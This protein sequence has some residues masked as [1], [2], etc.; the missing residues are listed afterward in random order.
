MKRVDLSKGDVFGKWVVCSFAGVRS[1]KKQYWTCVCECGKMKDL[2]KYELI[3]GKTTHCGCNRKKP[4]GYGIDLSGNRYGKL[5][6]VSFAYRKNRRPYW[7]CIC[8]CG[9][10]KILNGESIK[11][12]YTTSCGCVFKKVVKEVN[13]THGLS[14][15][16][17]YNVWSTMRARC[18]NPNNKSYERYGGRGIKVCK[19][20]GKFSNFYEDMGASYEAGLSIERLKVNKGYYK[21]NCIWS[22]TET[23]SMNK[24]NTLRVTI[25]GK[26]MTLK[27]WCKLSEISYKTAFRRLKIGWE[28]KDA[29]FVKLQRQRK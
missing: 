24:T 28:P 19:R 5:T 16:P 20:W 14:N 15:T 13:K 29:V 18:N 25:D 8:D 7:N 27:D 10:T 21:S 26:T 22:D 23:Q 6:I 17:I 1:G 9:K 2:C 4:T 12:G 3:N 11:I